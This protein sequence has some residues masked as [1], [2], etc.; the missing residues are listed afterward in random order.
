MFKWIKWL[1]HPANNNKY[2]N[3]ELVNLDSI[4]TNRA[5]QDFIDIYNKIENLTQTVE[6]LGELTEAFLQMDYQELF[7]DGYVYRE[8]NNSGSFT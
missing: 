2:D 7:L 8:T 4:F 6:A 5:T 1:F 3:S